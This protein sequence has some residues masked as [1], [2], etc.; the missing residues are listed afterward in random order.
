MPS[1]LV[2]VNL[3]IEGVV[4][5]AGLIFGGWRERAAALVYGG[6][7]LLAVLLKDFTQLPPMWRY[8]TPD[9]LCLLGF[10]VLCWKSPHPWPIWACGA[11]LMSVCISIAKGLNLYVTKWSYYTALIIFG[12]AVILALAVGVVRAILQRFRNTNKIQEIG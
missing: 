1:T 6:A 8:L 12:Y 10:V 5:M 3:A 4:C 11:Q 7:V 9:S 2:L